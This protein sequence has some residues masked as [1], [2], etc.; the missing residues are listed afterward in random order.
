M[1]REEVWADI[2]KAYS[3]ERAHTGATCAQ[4]QKNASAHVLA[5]QAALLAGLFTKS[6]TDSSGSDT[7]DPT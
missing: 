4:A 5:M 6:A 1:S 7:S 2:E 3:V